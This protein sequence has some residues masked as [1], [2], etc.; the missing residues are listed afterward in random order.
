[1]CLIIVKPPNIDIPRLELSRGF[2]ANDDGAGL[3]YSKD[4]KLCIRKGVFQTFIDFG[5]M[6]EGAVGD[7]SNGPIVVHFRTATSGQ[8][9]K[10]N[11]H[12][13]CVNDKLALV[14]NGVFSEISGQL[15]EWSD[16][17]Y[18]TGFLRSLPENFME[19]KSLSFLVED[20]VKEENS[21][22]V[23]MSNLGRITIINSSAGMWREGCWYSN[24]MFTSTVPSVQN[25]VCD[26]CKIK[27]YSYNALNLHWN[28]TNLVRICDTC[29]GDILGSQQYCLECGSGLDIDKFCKPC[30][31][32]YSEKD[33]IFQ[34]LESG[35][36]KKLTYGLY[37]IGSI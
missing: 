31:K 11:C 26:V 20:F 22:V 29:Q 25:L 15:E 18:F 19:N 34:F 16:T 32:I 6:Y 21:K 30:N 33:L 12:P 27:Q 1:M 28:G 8:K 2:L 36:D 24:R 14:H 13:F 35:K 10:L 9:N 7:S 23:F 3:M 5:K 17:A 37:D 4:E